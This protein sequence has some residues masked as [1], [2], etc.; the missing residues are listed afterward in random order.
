[1]ISIRLA[2]GFHAA[3]ALTS[4]VRMFTHAVSLGGVESLLQH[5]ASLTHRP[6]V[7]DAKPSADLV[8]ISIGLEGV[9]DV[10]ADL[11]QALDAVVPAAGQQGVSAG[12]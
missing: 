12:A 1:M 10:I 4:G 11:K 9:D 2:G 6:V 8:R 5:P 3:Q 7:A